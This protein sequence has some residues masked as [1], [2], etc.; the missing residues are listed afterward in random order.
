MNTQPLS[1]RVLDFWFGNNV[2]SHVPNQKAIFWFPDATDPKWVEQQS[3]GLAYIEE[4]FLFLIR[5]AAQDGLQDW[6]QTPRE[7]LALIL[8]LDQFAPRLFH[9]TEATRN[10]QDLALRHC[11]HGMAQRFQ[12]H[13]TPVELCFFYGPLLHSEKMAPRSIGLKMLNEILLEVR[14]QDNPYFQQRNHVMQCFYQAIKQHAA[15][16]RV[17]LALSA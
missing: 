11:R 17:L 16:E 6:W 2:H 8:L 15:K 9:S 13:L 1:D 4:H 10:S 14:C 7:C 5:S 3:R 12:K